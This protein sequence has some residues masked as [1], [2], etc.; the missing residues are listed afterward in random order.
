MRRLV[1]LDPSRVKFAGFDAKGANFLN[2][3]F[4]DKIHELGRLADSKSAPEIKLGADG[5]PKAP[6]TAQ[7]RYLR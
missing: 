3:V 5:L 1:R 4:N 6:R 7:C 2:P